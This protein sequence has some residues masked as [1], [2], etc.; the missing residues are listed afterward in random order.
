M[1]SIKSL[2]GKYLKMFKKTRAEPARATQIRTETRHP[3]F[4]LDSY[5]PAG[6]A[7]IAV[8]RNIR[9]ALPVLDSAVMKM[10]RLTGGFS[11][12]CT[13]KTAEA[14]LSE[15]IR[16]VDTGR[17][18]RGLDSFLS[19][20]IDSMITAGRAVGEIVCVGNSEIAA[21]VCADV[22]DIQI[23]EGDTP[24]DFKLCGYNET[25]DLVEY[26]YQNLLLFTP[27]NPETDNP[28]GV[29]MFR[30]MPFLAETLLKIY[31]TIGINWERAGNIRYA[32]T[33]KPQSDLLDRSMAKERAEQI[34]T[35]WSSAMQ[36]SKNGSVRDFVAVG[37]VDISVIGSD[38]QILDS[39]TPVQQ[40]LEQLISRTGIPPFMLGLSWSST[41]R[42]SAQ[43][44]DLMTSEITAIRRSLTPVIEKI[45]NLW[46]SMHGYSCNFEVL[47]DDINLQDLLEEAQ[48]ELY[49]AQTE[50]IRN[51]VI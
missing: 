8:Y 29:S 44:A 11:V 39:E 13:D 46:L 35:E 28:Y 25:G 43:Q 23:K 4:A 5:V 49:K 22:C 24:L 40:I 7:E 47:W 26:P 14:K 18:Q 30:S 16:T 21:V 3:F 31:N 2:G 42:M 48:A 45:C 51:E 20:Y 19:M 41:E 17:G 34:A 12:S 9:E 36:A 38:G 27:H 10:V 33:Y 1:I 50:V 32:V 6:G 37:D 15:F